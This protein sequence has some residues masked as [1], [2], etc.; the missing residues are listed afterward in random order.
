MSQ[1]FRSVQD[2]FFPPICICC[3]QC[4]VI[5][6]ASSVELIC[7]RCCD[8]FFESS[9]RST[10]RCKCCGFPIAMIENDADI[11]FFPCLECRYWKFRFSSTYCLGAYEGRLKQL[12]LQAKMVSGMPIAFALGQTLGTR[13]HPLSP[14]LVIP[15]PMHWRR[16]LTRQQSSAEALARGICSRAESRLVVETRAVRASRLTK[17]QGMLLPRQRRENVRNAFQVTK[18]EVISGRRV[19]LVD[20]VMTTGATLHE[21]TGQLLRHGASNVAVA[22]VCRAGANS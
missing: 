15:V 17:K 12:V 16:R 18:P 1:F 6:D 11:V 3:R 20:D 9:A 8:R 22:V 5:E 4:V 2:L 13:L 7:G 21:I 14:D 10:G 19:L